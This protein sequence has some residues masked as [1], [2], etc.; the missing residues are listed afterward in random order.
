MPFKKLAQLRGVQNRNRKMQALR[1][2]QEHAASFRVNGDMIDL[3]IF[4][5]SHL[6]QKH[7]ESHKRAAFHQIHASTLEPLV[8]STVV[9]KDSISLAL[10]LEHAVR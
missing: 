1:L 10:V 5:L 7:Q 2:L 3:A 9:P 4:T 6:T 8:E